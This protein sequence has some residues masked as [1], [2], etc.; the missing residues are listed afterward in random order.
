[1]NIKEIELTNIK[2]IQNKL[3]SLNL[4]PNKPNI[5]VAPNGFGKSSIGIGFNSLKPK[6]IAPIIIPGRFRSVL[7]HL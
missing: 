7:P 4:I 2:G 1:M 5:F 6:K 3:F